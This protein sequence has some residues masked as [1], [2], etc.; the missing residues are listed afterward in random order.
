MVA[1]RPTNGKTSFQ[2]NLL[3]NM[4]RNPANR[5]DKFHFFSYEETKKYIVA[6]LIMIMAGEVLDENDNVNAYLHHLTEYCRGKKK[7]TKGNINRAIEEFKSYTTDEADRLSIK[8]LPYK[9]K[10]L[11]GL[12]NELGQVKQIGAVFIDYIQKIP[13]ESYFRQTDRYLQIKIVSELL[14]NSAKKIDIPLIVGAQM[15]RGAM[16]NK[17]L[18]LHSL[19]ESGDLEQDANVVLG[20]NKESM[21]NEDLDNGNG[22]FNLQVHILKNRSGPAGSKVTL[23]FDG[24]VLQVNDQRTGF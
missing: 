19:R 9:G 4:L 11:A 14:L 8:D 24:R 16:G 23:G 21:D 1:A 13:L 22:K 3:V 7:R 10:E 15:N 20:L 5:N 2:L 17:E 18:M 12:I 6:K